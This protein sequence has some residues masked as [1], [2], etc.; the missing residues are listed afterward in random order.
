M[1]LVMV[2][3]TLSC[4]GIQAS[5]VKLLDRCDGEKA[6]VL[7]SGILE[8][9]VPPNV[10]VSVVVA[11]K[12]TASKALRWF[13][14]LKELRSTII[15]ARPD[16]VFSMGFSVNALVILS[17]LFASRK[18]CLVVGVRNSLR[19]LALTR[20][21]WSFLRIVTPWIYRY[22]DLV[23]S[24]SR[25]IATEFGEA[26]LEER[27]I[28]VIH[29]GYDF[30]KIR[31]LAVSD[32]DH[33]WYTCK[34]LPLIIS[35]GRLAAQKNFPLLLKAF[36]IVS[37][38]TP[39]RLVLLGEGPEEGRLKSLAQNLG[40]GRNVAFL[41]HRGNPYG[42]FARSDVFVLPS[43]WE[44]FPNVLCEA[45]ACGLPVV[46]TACPTGPDEIIRDGDNGLLVPMNDA[47]ALAEALLKLL[48]DERL[49]RSIARRGIET[50]QSLSIG[51]MIAE[52]NAC[53]EQI[54]K[55]D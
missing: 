42:F 13:R 7:L 53:F 55:A 22:A 29:N 43:L 6:L 5:A 9:S 8:L 52:Y 3:D 39:C 47:N 46:S 31:R 18:F 40:I 51:R 17:L 48:T 23:I 34:E 26:G 44:G 16:I 2:L 21:P 30:D 1:K 49:R 45:M 14:C 50:V 35:A 20:R 32:L 37:K 19:E 28:K 4:G 54:M 33:E 25:G 12:T 38:Q 36:Q 10:S 27:K 24:V 41:G 15:S 11:G